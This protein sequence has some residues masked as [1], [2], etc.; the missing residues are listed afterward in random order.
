MDLKRILT[1]V[2]GLPLVIITI[3]FGNKYLIDTLFTIIA[4]ICMHEYLGVIEK[5]SH[6]IKWIAYLS[7]L[8]VSAV[9]F[10]EQDMLMKGIVFSIPIIILK[11]IRLQI[12]DSTRLLDLRM[13]R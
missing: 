9:S 10:L 13:K 11:F 3:I 2:L 4:I 6:P 12:K 1:A 8:G 5:V 7:T